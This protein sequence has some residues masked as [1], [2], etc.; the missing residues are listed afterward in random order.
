[1]ILYLYYVKHSTYIT[2]VSFCKDLQVLE[3]NKPSE[4]SPHIP[5]QLIN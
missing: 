4:A 2:R 5:A 3:Y 1:M